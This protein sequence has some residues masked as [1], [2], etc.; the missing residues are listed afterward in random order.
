MSVTINIPEKIYHTLEQ[1]AHKREMES[2]EQ[3]LE[4]LT[5][6]F[7]REEAEAWNE[8][9]ERRREVGKEIRTF[10]Q[11]MKEKYGVMPDSTEIIREDRMRG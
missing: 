5:E 3:F 6:Q 2:V 8:E 10:R 4:K 11:Q 1:Q 9:L 7:E